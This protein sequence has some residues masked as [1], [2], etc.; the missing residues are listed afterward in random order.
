MIRFTVGDQITNGVTTFTILRVDDNEKCYKVI[1]D[2]LTTAKLKFDTIDDNYRYVGYIEGL[3]DK[4]NVIVDSGL[5]NNQNTYNRPMTVLD[6]LNKTD[7]SKGG[8]IIELYYPSC[9][10]KVT[11]GH[12]YI[13][14]YSTLYKKFVKAY[15]DMIV[16]EIS[17]DIK[18]EHPILTIKV[19]Y[20]D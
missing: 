12:N 19:D 9:G 10:F 4:V 17:L 13:D 2:Y 15:G 18:E 1:T 14:R 11:M 6:I 16:D 8:L 20:C 7:L 3:L 5:L